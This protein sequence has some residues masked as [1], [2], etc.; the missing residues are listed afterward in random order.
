MQTLILKNTC[1]DNKCQTENKW[2]SF[3]INNQ[4][5]I[6]GCIYRHPKGNID[7]FTSAL[8]NTISHIN[9]N[10]LAI[11]LGDINI[12]LMQESDA[13]VNTYINNFF[14]HNFIPCITLPT[15]ITHHSATLLDHIF[16]KSPKKL[17]QNKCSSGNFIADL[18]DHLPNFTFL[19]IETKSVK[20]RPYTRIFSQ[21][22]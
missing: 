11:I 3:K 17:I 9:D 8:K 6:I 18:S 10:T 13:K 12:D 21:K 4:K 2:V 15:R 1:T 20:D 16:I 5:V 7:H 19:D 14:E 22:I